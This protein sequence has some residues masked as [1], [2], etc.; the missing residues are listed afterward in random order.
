MSDSTAASGVY[1]H[2]PFCSSRCDY[3]AFAT[4]T[5]RHHLTGDYLDA[6]ATEIDR[7][8]ADGMPAATSIF[9][10]G[11]TPSLVP[12]DALVAV[13]D[14]IPRTA[15]VEVTVEANPDA[16]TA[17]SLRTYRAG[18]VT[19]MSFGVQSMAPEVLLSLGRTHDPDN[20]R[21]A[22]AWTK[23]AGFET[24]NLD[25]I[26]G[27]AAESD[28]AWARTLSEVV[29]LEPTHISA[30]SLTIEPGTP[31][32]DDESRHPDDDDQATKYL[33]TV[34]ALGSAGYDWYEVSN[35]ALPGHECRHNR[36]YWDAGDYLGFGCAA[37]SHRD[38]RRWWNLRTPERYIEAVRSGDTTE[39]TGETLDP[40]T[41]RI[42]A[43]QLAL[44][45]RGGVPVA[46]LDLDDPVLEG[47]VAV[48]ADRAVLT[49]EGRLL[50]NEVAIRL[51]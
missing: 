16:V 44:R 46:A 31:L 32:A 38:G 40:E 28:E 41:R 22:V 3:C 33:H 10:G 15:D 21:R 36:L 12:A 49:P 8:V 23:D 37:H 45:T 1:V 14:H 48:V 47:L 35:W 20:V 11:G 42:E 7:A 5:D 39:A 29:A 24:F 13:L 18:G 25:L 34:E 50:A 43:L 17:E 51:R 27:A 19:R 9:V 26:M 2:I 30:Y 4:W 6:V